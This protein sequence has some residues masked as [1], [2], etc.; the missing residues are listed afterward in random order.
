MSRAGEI[1]PARIEIFTGFIKNQ[2]SPQ[3]EVV[4]GSNPTYVDWNRLR[5]FMKKQASG[6]SYSRHFALY[7]QKQRKRRHKAAFF[8]IISRAASIPTPH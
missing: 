2:K 3:G 8:I 1:Q 4:G 5:F 6:G 7:L